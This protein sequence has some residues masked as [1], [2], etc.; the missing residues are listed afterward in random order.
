M[1]IEKRIFNWNISIRKVHPRIFKP[2]YEFELKKHGISNY[3]REPGFLF[4]FGKYLFDVNQEHL[5]EIEV[6]KECNGLVRG[7]GE[8]GISYCE[9][10][11]AIVEGYTE[12]ITIEEYDS[13]EQ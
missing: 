10:C 5:E 6:H 2:W 12:R 13:R 7:I 11:E 8:D 3:R 1:K 4:Y 9:L